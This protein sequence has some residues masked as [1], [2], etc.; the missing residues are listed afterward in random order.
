MDKPKPDYII[1]LKETK[2]GNFK[3]ITSDTN[4]HSC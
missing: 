2:F 3:E 4:G 1:S